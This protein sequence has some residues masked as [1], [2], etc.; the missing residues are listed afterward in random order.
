VSL[1]RLQCFVAGQE[2]F[3]S[4][5]H[6][7]GLSLAAISQKQLPGIDLMA[8]KAMDDWQDVADIYFPLSKSQHYNRR[9]T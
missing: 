1:G 2:I 6:E 9:K 4:V 3:I 5:S 8:V 7:P